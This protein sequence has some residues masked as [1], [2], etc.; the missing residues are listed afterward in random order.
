MQE[1][2]AEILT[3]GDEILYGQI[4]DTNSQWISSQLSDIGIKT[5][6]KST[7]GDDEQDI[8]EALARA[9]S[10]ANIILITGGLG[11]TKDDLTK[12]CLAKYFKTEIKVNKK[13]LADVKEFFKRFGRELTETNEK[14]AEL[15]ANSIHI[16]NT[17][18]TAPG[19][20]FEE[21]NKIFVSMPGVPHEM[22]EMMAISILPRLQN[23]FETPIIIHKLI[24]TAGIGE[25]YLSDLIS[26]WEGNLPSSIK[27]AYLPGFGQ[28][29]LRLTCFGSDKSEM[30]ALI[31][32]QIE[33]LKPLAFKYIYGYDKDELEKVIG[34]ELRR[35]NLKIATAESC[36]G[37]YVA[38]TITSIAGSSEYFQGGVVP[39]H[40]AFKE[41]ILDVEKDMLIR[42]GAV[43]EETVIQMAEKVKSLFKADI[44][45]STS[46][47]AGPGGG[48]DEKP[49]GTVWIG[50]SG[51]WGTH[52]RKYSFGGDRTA[53]IH[54]TT[55]TALHLLWQ[56]LVEID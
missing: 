26:D 54:F 6:W 45:V 7:V 23:H 21:K 51:P 16:T 27:L 46:G 35:K 55:L 12:V 34:D 22:K 2:F 38:K 48:T 43:S 4:T 50:I 28:V 30:E 9:E 32:E 36:T 20:W 18:G 24:K 15:P 25:S 56:R 10:R 41:K 44:G 53:N 33:K 47:V 3:I 17:R 1:I 11:P 29:K 42:M 14:Q 52:A 40:N 13:A 8:L 5:R 49:V 37:G 31:N 39:Y 19:M